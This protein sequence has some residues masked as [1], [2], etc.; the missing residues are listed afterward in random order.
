[1][2]HLIFAA[3]TALLTM[4]LS[5]AAF[6]QSPTSTSDGRITSQEAVAGIISELERRLIGDYFGVDLVEREYDQGKKK[7]KG[8]GKSNQLPPG[9]AKRDSLPP[10]LQ[11]QLDSRGSLPPG[12]AKRDLPRDLQSSLPRRVAEQF[13]IVDSDIVL[14]ERATGL[15]LDVI[16]NAVTRQG[17]ADN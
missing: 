14:V 1:M 8:Q 12:L 4:T 15:V 5:P 17:R 6:A 2:R 9:L 10:G 13:V 3:A 16:E 7:N 11:M